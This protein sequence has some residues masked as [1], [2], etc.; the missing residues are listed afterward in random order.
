MFFLVFLYYTV[1]DFVKQRAENG[2]MGTTDGLV[3]HLR[4]D[5]GV[6]LGG[7]GGS[8]S[9]WA[10]QSGMG[11]DFFAAGNPLLQASGPNGQPYIEFDGNGDLLLVVLEPPCV[12]SFITDVPRN[13]E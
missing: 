7:P 6:T 10:D 1:G 11:N 4:A 5:S 8:V 2:A 9:A 13:V 3:L 12:T